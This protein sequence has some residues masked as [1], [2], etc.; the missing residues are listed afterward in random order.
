M[1]NHLTKIN[2]RKKGFILAFRAN[3]FLQSTM[4]RN[5]LR[6]TAVN[7]PS[8]ARKQSEQ[9]EMPS[10]ETSNLSLISSN[11][12]PPPEHSHNSNQCHHLDGDHESMTDLSHLNHKALLQQ[13]RQNHCCCPISLKKMVNFTDVS[14]TSSPAPGISLTRYTKEGRN[15]RPT[16][17]KSRICGPDNYMILWKLPTFSVWI[18]TGRKGYYIQR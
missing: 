9:E 18:H 2:L 8:G 3:R 15:D 5:H 1:T 16:H 10:Y 13:H 14:V 4:V 11:N 12:A 6:N 7:I 17:Q